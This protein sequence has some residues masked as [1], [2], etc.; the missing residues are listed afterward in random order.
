MASIVSVCVYF[1]LFVNYLSNMTS[2]RLL[3][4]QH[5]EAVKKVLVPEER[6]PETIS[7]SDAQR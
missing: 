5:L 4:P 3:N 2:L 1:A 6:P 7:T